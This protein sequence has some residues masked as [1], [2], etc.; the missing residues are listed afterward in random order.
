MIRNKRNSFMYSCMVSAKK[1]CYRPIPY[2][3]LSLEKINFLGASFDVAARPVHRPLRTNI[4]SQISIH[5]NNSV[6]S[7]V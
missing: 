5:A 6:V 7:S 4:Y 3:S 2:I 1:A